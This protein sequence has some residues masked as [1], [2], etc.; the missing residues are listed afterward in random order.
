MLK[1]YENKIFIF[2]FFFTSLLVFLSRQ[3][4]INYINKFPKKFYI[5]KDPI[6]NPDGYFFLNNIKNQLINNIG[7]FEKLFR[8][9]F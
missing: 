7:F 6:L 4:Q 1:K 9:I 2:V 5:F 3:I 8:K